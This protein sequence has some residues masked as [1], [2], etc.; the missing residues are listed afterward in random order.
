MENKQSNFIIFSGGSGSGKTTTANNIVDNSDY[1]HVVSYTTRAKRDYFEPEYI[2]VTVDDFNSI[3]MA[4][5]I[6]VTKDWLY[7]ADLKNFD[8]SNLIYSVIDISAALDIKK[9][10]SENFKNYKITIVKFEISENNRDSLI[11]EREN[12]E[13]KK[14]RFDR[15]KEQLKN[16]SLEYDFLVT[17]FGESIEKL[18][19]EIKKL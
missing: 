12:E 11:S 2:F 1:K 19:E 9:Y 17:N 18:K 3:K 16:H 10:V 4:N 14:V 15:E 5:R 8:G 13:T 7:G 6:E